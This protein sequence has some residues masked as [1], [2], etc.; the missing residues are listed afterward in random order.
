[1]MS[2]EAI[3]KALGGHRSGS[4]WMACCPAHDDR[5]PSLSIRQ[6]PDGRVLVKCFAGCSQTDVIDALRA[7]GL[8]KSVG[9]KALARHNAVSAPPIEPDEGAE[10]RIEAARKIIASSVPSLGTLV[11]NYL[12]SRNLVV[13]PSSSL[14]FHSGLRHPSGSIWPA[15]V[16]PVT[17]ASDGGLVGIHRTFLARDGSGKAPI[18]SAK[19]M[20]G[21]CA[22][23][24]V[25]LAEPDECLMVGE[26]IETCLAAMQA[27]GNPAWAALST[28]GLKA[29]IL[30]RQVREVII[31]ADGDEGGEAAA[32]ASALRWTREGRTV[33]IA[34]PPVGMDFNDLLNSN[35]ADNE[36]AA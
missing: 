15:M 13:P 8:W 11:E 3:G 24:A 7:R 28:S 35:K 10:W 36:E 31:L 25:H 32:K 30:P 23:C 1:M 2:A 33:R 6:G 21:P 19:M 9:M 14:R 27:T 16:A 29:L 22:E 4:V 5:T 34:R 17:R 12:R 18:E 20:L 26:G